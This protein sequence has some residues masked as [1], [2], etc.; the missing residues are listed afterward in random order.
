MLGFQGTRRSVV[1]SYLEIPFWSGPTHIRQTFP[2]DARSGSMSNTTVGGDVIP[3]DITR[4]RELDILAWSSSRRRHRTPG[5]R[6]AKSPAGCR[7]QHFVDLGLSN[8]FL[9]F[10]LEV[11]ITS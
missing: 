8:T 10:W 7:S 11:F 6:V 3:A 9:L 2:R 5:P 4:S 1:K